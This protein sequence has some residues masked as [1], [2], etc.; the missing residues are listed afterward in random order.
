MVNDRAFMFTCVPLVVRLFFF[1]FYFQVKVIFQCQSQ[2]S[3]SHFFLFS[4]VAILE[5]SVFHKHTYCHK[6]FK[7]FPEQS[8]FLTFSQTTNFRLFQN[9]R[10]CRRQFQIRTDRK[11]WGKRRNCLL[12]AVSSFPTVFP[13][14]LYYRHVWERVYEP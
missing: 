13:K 5:A 1:F 2:I 8:Q 14:D 6:W 12:Q 11:H 7:L 10:V 3:R 9:E 4:K